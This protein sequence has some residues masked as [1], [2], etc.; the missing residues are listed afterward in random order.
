MN[1]KPMNTF[2]RDNSNG[3]YLQNVDLT[4]AELLPITGDVR[5]IDDRYVAMDRSGNT[6]SI[7]RIGSKLYRLEVQFS[8]VIAGVSVF[9]NKDVSEVYTDPTAFFVLTEIDGDKRDLGPEIYYR[10]DQL[11]GLSKLFSSAKR[12]IPAERLAYILKY[13]VY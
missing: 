2:L 12:Q 1:N 5:L 9:T 13:A 6:T 4:Q 3:R 11:V 8:S 10:A 7:L